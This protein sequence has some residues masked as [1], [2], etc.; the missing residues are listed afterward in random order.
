MRN[1]GDA[2][3]RPAGN[4]SPPITRSIAPRT[5]MNRF[6]SGCAH[7]QRRMQFRSDP[8]WMPNDIM[9]AMTLGVLL[10]GPR[11]ERWV[12]ECVKHALTVPGATAA[13]ERLLAPTD[14][15]AE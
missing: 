14:A 1:A 15:V 5:P 12:L 13:S 9:R 11:Q 3:A 6:S 10:H 2:P 4:I 7:R 8:R